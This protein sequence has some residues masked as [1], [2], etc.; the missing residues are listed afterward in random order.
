MSLRSRKAL[1]ARV[2]RHLVGAGG[3]IG[4]SVPAP[5]APAATFVHVFSSAFIMA[6]QGSHRHG[7]RVLPLHC[8]D[9]ETIFFIH[10]LLKL[11][12]SCQST[13]A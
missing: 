7:R 11:Q 8:H 1:A 4:A 9:K 3:V 5:P 13:T 12:E 2:G 6:H 10:S